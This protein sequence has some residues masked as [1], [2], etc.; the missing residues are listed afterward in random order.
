MADQYLYRLHL[1]T[2]FLTFVTCFVLSL[3]GF[4]LGIYITNNVQT[5]TCVSGNAFMIAENIY[6]C[7]QQVTKDAP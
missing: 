7:V 3:T 1:K 2:V 5:K 6:R 4:G